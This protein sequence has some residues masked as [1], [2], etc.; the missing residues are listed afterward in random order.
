MIKPGTAYL[1][2]WMEIFAQIWGSELKEAAKSMKF[3][4]L[5]LTIRIS[6]GVNEGPRLH[7]LTGSIKPRSLSCID[8]IGSAL[9]S[10]AQ[11]I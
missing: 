7:R 10:S 5:L 3:T 6:T 11:R 8:G 2:H 4:T 1:D 9:R